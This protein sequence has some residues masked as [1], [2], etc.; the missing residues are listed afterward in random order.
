MEATQTAR[1]RSPDQYEPSARANTVLHTLA[2][3]AD[4]TIESFTRQ[5]A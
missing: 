1:W 5:L 3:A 4:N 2:G